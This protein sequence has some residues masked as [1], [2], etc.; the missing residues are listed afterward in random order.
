MTAYI[1]GAGASSHAGYPL[2][3]RLLQAV[4]EWLDCKDDTEHWV[5]DYRNRIIQVRETFG[6][7]DDFE[8]ILGKLG[9]YGHSRVKSH[10]PTTYRQDPKDIFHDCTGRM[11]G[12]D[13]GNPDTPLTGFYP[14]YLRS[15]LISAFR[16]YF[17]EIE[18]N[19]NGEI[20]YDSFARWIDPPSLIIT[21]NY[22]V[23]LAGQ[24]ASLRCDRQDIRADHH[25]GRARLIT[26]R[27]SPVRSSSSGGQRNVP[28]VGSRSPSAGSRGATGRPRSRRNRGRRR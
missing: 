28:P 4:S 7:L 10:G 11:R 2:A 24:R 27:G 17:H 5:R 6:S 12:V 18:T 26:A 3:S 1:L 14:Q 21:L 22:D 23:A 19:R 8:S 15:D 13:L 25:A 16:E 20:A 9:E